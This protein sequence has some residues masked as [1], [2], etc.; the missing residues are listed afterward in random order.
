MTT[1]PNAEDLQSYR[2]QGG[3]G[4]TQGGLKVCWAASVDEARSSVHRMWRNMFVPGQHSQDLPLPRHFDQA[5][6][7]V[8]EDMVTGLPLGPDPEE[9]IKAVSEYIDA[10]F[11]EVYVAQIG[12]DQAGMIDFYERAALRHVR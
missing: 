11:D 4:R 2:E 12:P 9:H 8:S 10:G 5:A 3:V 7:L 1:M 6:S